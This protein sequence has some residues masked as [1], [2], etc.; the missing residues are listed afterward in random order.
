MTNYTVKIVD[1][2][3][4]PPVVNIGVGDT[5]T[6]TNQDT[7]GHSARRDNQPAFDTG[8]IAKGDTSDPIRFQTSGS[9]DYFCRQHP[10]MVAKVVAT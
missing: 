4:D 10:F 2:A 5:I 9:F 1:M 8:L 3:F 6:W 7:V